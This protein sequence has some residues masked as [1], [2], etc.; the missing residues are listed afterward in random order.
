MAILNALINT[1][2]FWNNGM[3]EYWLTDLNLFLKTE[4]FLYKNH[5]S[6]IPTFQHSK[7]FE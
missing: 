7:N 2:G 4:G 3:M 6:T 1:L 5:Y